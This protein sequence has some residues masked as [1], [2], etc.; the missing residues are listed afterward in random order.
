[1]CYL[2]GIICIGSHK[3]LFVNNKRELCCSR[4]HPN[5][6]SKRRENQVTDS[7]TGFLRGC[8]VSVK[9]SV[10]SRE[11]GLLHLGSLLY[12]GNFHKSLDNNLKSLNCCIIR[13]DNALHNS[14]F[15]CI[16]QQTLLNTD[17]V[18]KSETFE[19][20][21]SQREMENWIILCQWLI[22]SRIERQQNK[23]KA[24]K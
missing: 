4:S 24:L 10:T 11:H 19:T 6:R 16:C 20:T 18:F 9:V 13:R 7:Q 8:Q 14:A 15:S 2:V 21:E 12:G 1:M 22:S 3:C 23:H 17:G 5:Y